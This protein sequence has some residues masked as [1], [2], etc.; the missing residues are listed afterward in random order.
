MQTLDLKII[1][2]LIKKALDED[3][4]ENGDVTSNLTISDSKPVKFQ[5]SNREEIILCG[6]DFALMVF[7]EVAQRLKNK[8]KLIINKKFSDGKKLKKN[9]IILQGIWDAKAV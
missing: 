9:S 6:V 1:Q 7:D 4:G 8:N 5:I 2:D 3:F